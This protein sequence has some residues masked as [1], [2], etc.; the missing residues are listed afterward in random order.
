MENKRAILLLSGGI[1]STTLLA[2]LT[3]EGYEIYALS[4]DY[5][6]KHKVELDFAQANAR[7]YKVKAHY[8]LKVDNQLFA[9]KSSLTNQTM[10]IKTYQSGESIQGITTATVPARNLLF[11]SYTVGFAE[12]IECEEI[13]IAFNQE[14]SHNFPDCT[15]EFVQA[16]NQ[17][18]AIQSSIQSPPQV[19]APLIY[20]SKAEVLALARKLGVDIDQTITC[21]QP[22]GKLECGQCLSCITKQKA[23]QSLAPDH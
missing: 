19:K 20:W 22:N 14:D 18:T 1:D 21:Y 3:Q 8:C 5:G 7:H 4:F 11:L 9:T 10:A 15:P 17:M 13:M 12:T 6:Q 16:F 23:L 2:K